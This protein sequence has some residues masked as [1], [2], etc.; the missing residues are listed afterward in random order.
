MKK[1]NLI[2]LTGVMLTV[3]TLPIFTVKAASSQEESD[4]AVCEVEETANE[5]D[6]NVVY[7]SGGGSYSIMELE[8]VDG[9]PKLP[10]SIDYSGKPE[11]LTLLKRGDIIYEPVAGSAVFFTYGHISVVVDIVY[12]EEYDQEYVLLIEAIKEPGV[13]YGIMTP[14]RFDALN[15]EVKRLKNVSESVIDD[16]T[17][18]MIGQWG[19]EYPSGIPMEKN[20]DPN[21]SDWYCS[22]LVW[23]AYYHQEIYLDPDENNSSGNPFILVD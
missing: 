2:L 14:E 7:S 8:V 9:E 3:F 21:S 4:S 22:E 10:Y 5:N 6:S 17:E 23:A 16:A 15:S 11:L 18:W 13:M 1:F 12:D 19:K 20:A